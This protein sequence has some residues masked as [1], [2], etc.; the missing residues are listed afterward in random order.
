[1]FPEYLK[2]KKVLFVDDDCRIFYN[3]LFYMIA[4]STTEKTCLRSDPV[5]DFHFRSILKRFSVLI[6]DEKCCETVSVGLADADKE[7]L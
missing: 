3:D 5:L 2:G 7:C 4:D 6:Q 1:M